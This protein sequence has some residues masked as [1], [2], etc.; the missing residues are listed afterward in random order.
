MSPDPSSR[1][2]ELAAGQVEAIVAA[3]QATAGEIRAEAQRERS[4]ILSGA[5]RDADRIREVAEQEAGRVREEARRDA[6][7]ELKR[8][9]LAATKVEDDARAEAEER[10]SAA[11]QAADEAL[12]DARV[13]SHGL[14]RLGAALDDQAERILRDVQAAH[15]RLSADLRVAGGVSTRSAPAESARAESAT[16]ETAKLTASEAEALT[17]LAERER[18][19]TGEGGDPS[20]HPRSRRAR[21]GPGSP[22][23][24]LDVPTWVERG[25]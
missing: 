19:A 9:R 20:Q 18:A 16:G 15:K 3:A 4:E 5:S 7:A 10:V 23:D 11:Q 22:V 25:S 8:A 12:E 17:R 13:M 6:D 1:A 14:R 21:R 24:D 2:A